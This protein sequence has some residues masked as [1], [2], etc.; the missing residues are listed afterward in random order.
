MFLKIILKRKQPVGAY[1]AQTIA[2][3]LIGQ[4][5][6]SSATDGFPIWWS[7]EVNPLETRPFSPHV[8]MIILSIYCIYM[9]I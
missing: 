3:V 8:I 2:T 5:F 6:F 4:F 7:D 9:Y 1:F